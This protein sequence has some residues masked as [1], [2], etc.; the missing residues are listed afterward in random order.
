MRGFE[1]QGKEFALDPGAHCEPMERV[2]E[3][4]HVV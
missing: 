3:R 1:G 4:H 2:E